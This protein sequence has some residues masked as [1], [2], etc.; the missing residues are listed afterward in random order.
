MT[1][2]AGNIVNFTALDAVT[3]NV[4][5]SKLYAHVGV[6]KGNRTG[7]DTSQAIPSENFF[8]NVVFE[9]RRRT[10]MQK[11]IAAESVCSIA[12]NAQKTLTCGQKP[13]ISGN[14]QETLLPPSSSS[15]Y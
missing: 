10:K 12:H 6:P 7:F 5:I 4:I 14:R 1:T 2:G 8:E 9:L 13:D 3:E 11:V 15:V